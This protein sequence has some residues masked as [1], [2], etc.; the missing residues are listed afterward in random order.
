MNETQAR[1]IAATVKTL[2]VQARHQV[3]LECAVSEVIQR[4]SEE[5]RDCERTV[6][7]S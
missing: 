6:A 5:P 7:P 2:A 1:A 4:L 3:R